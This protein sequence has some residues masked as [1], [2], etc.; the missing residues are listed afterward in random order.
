MTILK[1]KDIVP[2]IA[3]DAWVAD[4]AIVAGD[5]HIGAQSS[6]WFG[7]AMRGD[8]HEIRIGER[9]NIQ[10]NVVVHV[11]R[12]VAGTYIG[13]DVTIG[14]AAV[15]HA[16]TIKNR[17]LIGMG[18]V[19]LDEVVIEEGAMVAAGAVVTPRKVVPSGQLWG[20]NPA[21]YMRDLSEEERDFLTVSANNYVRLAKEY[22]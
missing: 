2:T 6:V 19:I 21:R 7:V 14:H 13:D 15:I 3:D 5:I 10:D 9:T 1:Y 18:A 12:G 4:N 8:V 17:C 20:G 16:A 11:T 22:K